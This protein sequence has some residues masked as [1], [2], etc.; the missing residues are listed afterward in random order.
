M[1]GIPAG[2]FPG[3][4]IPVMPTSAATQN[5][6]VAIMLR[7]SPPLFLLQAPTTCWHCRAAATVVAFVSGLV[8][9][10]DAQGRVIEEVTEPGFSGML[11]MISK[12][13]AGLL[14]I[15][16]EANPEYRLRPSQATKSEYFANGCAQCGMLFGD[17]FLHDGGALDPQSDV[18]ASRISV[19][20]VHPTEHFLVE[21]NCITGSAELI[22]ENGTRLA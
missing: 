12:I 9:E 4:E 3:V 7:I 14:K 16:T 11:S 1:R 5:H 2:I 17:H 18:A 19:R 21:A 10:V 20:D 13:P 22:L 15:A 8:E 6:S